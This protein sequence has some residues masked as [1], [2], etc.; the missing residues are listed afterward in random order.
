MHERRGAE[1]SIR[2]RQRMAVVR[3]H[4]RQDLGAG[5]VARGDHD[6]LL[7]GCPR[8]VGLGCER[9][10]GVRRGARGKRGRQAGGAHRLDAEMH[11][12]E[13][14]REHAAQHTQTQRA[15]RAARVRACERRG[16][17]RDQ[18][19]RDQRVEA[20]RDRQQQARLGQCARQQRPTEQSAEP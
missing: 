17:Q 5:E 15:P 8:V 18:H 3:A 20:E 6:P 19:R 14:E 9:P 12:A 16:H 2:A 1:E 11:R 7:A 10:G 4:E 13:R